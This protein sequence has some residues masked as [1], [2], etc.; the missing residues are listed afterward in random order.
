MKNDGTKTASTQSIAMSS[1]KATS[2]PQSTQATFPGQSRNGPSHVWRLVEFIADLDIRR[3][4]A[5]ELWQVFPDQ[6]D[7]RKRGGIGALGNGD[8]DGAA[9]VHQRVAGNDVRGVLHL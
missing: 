4:H 5:L 3:H 1:S 7:H 9:T 6:I 8:I 2:W